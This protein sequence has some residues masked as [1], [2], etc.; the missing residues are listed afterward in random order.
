MNSASEFAGTNKGLASGH[1]DMY[2]KIPHAFVHE[3]F[4]RWRLGSWI[5]ESRRYG[6]IGRWGIDTMFGECFM[7]LQSKS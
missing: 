4:S 5:Y 2:A 7:L 1:W 3:V 6:H